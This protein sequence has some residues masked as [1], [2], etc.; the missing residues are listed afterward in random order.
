MKVYVVT[1]KTESG[2]DGVLGV[3][4]TKPTDTYLLTV[5]RESMPE[6]HSY[7]YW[8]VTEADVEDLPITVEEKDI[9]T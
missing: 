4:S 5:V 6:E 9:Q 8:H 2:D 1:F 3:Y 7:V